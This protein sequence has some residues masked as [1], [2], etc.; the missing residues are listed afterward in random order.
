MPHRNRRPIRWHKLTRL[1][2]LA[3][4]CLNALACTALILPREDNNL[5]ETT[6]GT[7]ESAVPGAPIASLP[8]AGRLVVTGVD[9][10]LYLL[11]AGFDPVALTN[12]AIPLESGLSGRVYLHPTWSSNGWLSY[13]LA[14]SL[15]EQGA[16]LEV[17]ALRPG[18]GDPTTILTT[19]SSNYIYGYWSPAPCPASPTCGRLAFLMNDNDG[20]SLHVAEISNGPS[21]QVSEWVAGRSSPF[22]FSWAPDGTTMLWHR[23]STILSIYDVGSA[24]ETLLPDIPG[25]FQA[26]AWSPVDMQW[27]FARDEDGFNRMTLAVG[28]TRIDLGLPIGGPAFFNWSPDGKQIAY[29]YGDYPLTPMTVINADGSEGRVLAGVENVV[30]A[31]W[32]PDSTRLAV[33][34]LEEYTPPLPQATSSE[35]RARPVTQEEGPDYVFTWSVIHVASGRVERFAEFLPTPE[36]FYIFQFFDQYAQSHQLWSPDGQFVAYAE[37]P[38]DGSDPIIR[39]IDTYDPDRE[40][41]RLM[42]GRQAIFSFDE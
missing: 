39:L 14:E 19:T 8:S 37:Q 30:A 40:P 26:P 36:Q 4:L 22:Y 32:S 3:A 33:V 20:F 17:I 12:D 42:L 41:L 11:R 5:V 34:A 10:N 2:L 38:M 15:P 9:G 18:E 7:A 24:H 29:T 21:P 23:D 13:V 31:F 28:E 25:S 27:V 35:L 1:V 16:R 6:E